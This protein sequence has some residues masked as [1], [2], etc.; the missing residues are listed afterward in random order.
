MVLRDVEKV[1]KI[2][3]A[4]SRKWLA[5]DRGTSAASS[6]RS[7]I[8]QATF[9]GIGHNRFPTPVLFL[10]IN[11]LIANQESAGW[12]KDIF[13]L[14]NLRAQ[15]GEVTERYEYVQLF[16]LCSSARP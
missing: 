12:C 11:A 4:T 13:D 2:R 9:N 16:Y 1:G 10:I 8:V 6:R 7:K 5:I 15:I 14:T 3:N